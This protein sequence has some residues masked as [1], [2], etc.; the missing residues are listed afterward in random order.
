MGSS[1]EG[2]NLLSANFMNLT[3]QTLLFFIL[4]TSG[5]LLGQEDP[6]VN[7]QWWLKNSGFNI[8]AN[9][10]N[11][12]KVA[13][14][15]YRPKIAIIDTGFD[16]FHED[17]KDSI[18]INMKEIPNN[19]IDDDENGYI[20]DYYGYNSVSKNGDVRGRGEHGTHIHG[21]ISAKHNNGVGIKG[22]TDGFDIIPIIKHPSMANKPEMLPTLVDAFEYAIS[23]GANIINFSQKLYVTSPAFE[24]VI[25]K[26]NKLNIII[27]T[28]AGNKAVENAKRYPGLYAVKYKNII[29]VAASTRERLMH[30]SSN[31]GVESVHVFAPGKRIFSTIHGNLYGYRSGTSMAAPIVTGIIALVLATHGLE[32]AFEM[33]E[34]I[35]KTSKRFEQMSGKVYSNGLVDAFSAITGQ[36]SFNLSWQ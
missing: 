34:R 24:K 6:L 27:V 36:T 3:A 2:P 35:I 23:R 29:T 19:G 31:F 13:Q 26:A 12:W 1:V 21:M 14:N 30:F 28:A 17:L 25:E 4:F 5:A 22:I 16:I 7:K 9:I 20:D 10:E 32:N 8:G 18:L 15:N 33:R 11:A